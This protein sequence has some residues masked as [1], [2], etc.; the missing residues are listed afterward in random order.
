MK[1]A[2]LIAFLLTVPCLA[3]DQKPIAQAT[4]TESSCIV[5]KRMGTADQVTSH[6]YSFGFRGKQ[7]QYV[8][9][10]LPKGV[11]FHGRLT[12]HDVRQI[13]DKGGKVRFLESKYTPEDLES[14]RKSC[15]S[16]AE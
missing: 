11:S 10:D 7:F 15:E 1:R 16:R 8:E 6:M 13:M 2:A 5:L 14:A 4:Q 9:G 3:Q 12:D